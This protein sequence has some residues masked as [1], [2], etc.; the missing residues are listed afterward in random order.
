MVCQCDGRKSARISTNATSPSGVF[1]P[2][3]T[4]LFLRVD[5]DEGGLAACGGGNGGA[6]AADAA[7]SLASASVAA[8]LEFIL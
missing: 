8:V 2:S 4:C 7:P 1:Q 5:L 3:E 6:A